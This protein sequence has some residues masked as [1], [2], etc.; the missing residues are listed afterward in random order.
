M[1]RRYATS[2][3]RW[4]AQLLMRSRISSRWEELPIELGHGSNGAVV[5]VRDEPRRPVEFLVRRLVGTPES[6]PW[7]LRQLLAFLW[8]L[9]TSLTLCRFVPAGCDPVYPGLV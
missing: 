8:P 6:L 3:G 1:T 2:G 4:L 5:Y 9:T 7:Q